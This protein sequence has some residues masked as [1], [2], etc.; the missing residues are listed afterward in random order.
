M[1]DTYRSVLGLRVVRRFQDRPVPAEDVEALLEAARWTG[2]SKNAQHWAFIVIEDAADRERVA[3]A[4]RFSAPVL[5]A[6]L[7]IAL[8]RTPGGNDFDIGR[9]AQN[10]MLAAAARRLGSCPVT[11]HDQPEAR[12]ALSIPPDHECR[13][14]VAVGYPDE[15]GEA[16]HRRS[17]RAVGVS[18]RKPLSDLVHRSRFGG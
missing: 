13:W 5:A 2:S 1:Q 7:T 3:A 17:L 6:P 15:G 11:L 16:E 4:G 10:I 8:V 12:R 14:V 18:G 9:C